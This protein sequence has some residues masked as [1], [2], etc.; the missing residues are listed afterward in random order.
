MLG[1]TPDDGARLFISEALNGQSDRVDP[2][3]SIRAELV[4]RGR[5]VPLS[6]YASLKPWLQ[7][8]TRHACTTPVTRREQGVADRVDAEYQIEGDHRND[9][10]TEGI[11]MSQLLE[12]CLVHPRVRRFLIVAQTGRWELYRFVADKRL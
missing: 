10:D 8:G 9:E 2:L 1:H 6:L 3:M 11:R 12:G 7:R 5:P 4:G